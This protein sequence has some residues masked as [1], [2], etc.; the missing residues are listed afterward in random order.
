MCHLSSHLG[1]FFFGD[2]LPR[3]L[4]AELSLKDSNVKPTSLKF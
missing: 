3:F 2:H 4:N 1:N